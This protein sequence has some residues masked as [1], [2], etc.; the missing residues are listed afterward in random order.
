MMRCNVRGSCELIGLPS[1]DP[2]KLRF[3]CHRGARGSTPPALQHHVSVDVYTQEDVNLIGLSK[4]RVCK[5]EIREMTPFGIEV[6]R[7]DG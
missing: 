3:K 4:V 6:D 5:V 7:L 2:S 1:K